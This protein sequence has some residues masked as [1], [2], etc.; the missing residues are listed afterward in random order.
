MIQDA[1]Q[2]R[3]K[4]QSMEDSEGL[5][6]RESKRQRKVVDYVALAAELQKEDTAEK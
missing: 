1:A 5:E 3:A 6:K 4:R 2:K